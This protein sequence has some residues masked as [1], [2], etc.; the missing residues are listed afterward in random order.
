MQR[1]PDVPRQPGTNPLGQALPCLTVSARVRLT[2]R[3]SFSIQEGSQCGHGLATGLIRTEY[4][5]QE[6][7]QSHQ[8]AV[9]TF[10]RAHTFF[11]K[12]LLDLVLRQELIN[13]RSEVLRPLFATRTDSTRHPSCDR[14]P[15]R[16]GL[17][18]SKRVFCRTFFYSR[19]CLC[20]YLSLVQ[21]LISW[22]RAIRS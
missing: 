8:R 12:H 14:L 5:R 13:F 17:H 16:K 6:R 2:G 15:H 7:P 4:L 20:S 9:D 22:G 21:L 11:T 1:P 19:G 3:A 18:A 10:T